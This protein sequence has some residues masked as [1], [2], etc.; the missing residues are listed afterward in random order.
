MSLSRIASVTIRGYYG[1]EALNGVKYG[2]V[3]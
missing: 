1:K 3:M 2:I